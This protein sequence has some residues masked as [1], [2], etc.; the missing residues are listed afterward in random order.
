MGWKDPFGSRQMTEAQNQYAKPFSL[1]GMYTPMIVVSGAMHTSNLGPAAKR[2]E[3]D[4]KAAA[5]ATIEASG[6]K[7][8]TGAAVDARLSMSHD[9]AQPVEVTVA[10][11]ENELTTDIK[12]GELKG[13]KV[14]EFA[15][16]R[17]LSKPATP[18]K[19][20]KVSF[21]V[22]LGKDWKPENVYLAIVARDPATRKVLGAKRIDWKDLA[23]PKK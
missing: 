7:T 19:D 8:D 12:S 17:F 10:A 15:V 14:T 23:A 22:P 9:E 6:T 18:G 4:G 20:G 21:E 5:V 16:V 13:H 3:D 1:R 11:A 2:I